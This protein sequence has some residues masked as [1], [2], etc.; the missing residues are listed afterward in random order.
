MLGNLYQVYT[1][2]RISDRTHPDAVDEDANHPVTKILE[3]IEK[4]WLKTDQDLFI[5]CF[6]LNPFINPTLRNANNLTIAVLMG[7][8]QWLY[9]CVFEVKDCPNDLMSQV[10]HYY[11]CEGVFSE[12]KWP[13]SSLWTGLKELV[14]STFIVRIICVYIIW[15]DGSIADPLRVWKIAPE[16]NPLVKLAILI[17]SFV[18]NSASTECLFS[19]MG[20]IKTKKR[21]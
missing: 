15:Q 5:V 18:P 10:Y 12:D 2:L 9:L 14:C 6:F 1:K 11:T 19:S 16:E 17:F 20:D 21:N 7:I 8:I 4:R 13:I 3:S